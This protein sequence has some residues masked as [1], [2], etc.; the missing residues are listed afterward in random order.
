MASPLSQVSRVQVPDTAIQETL[1]VVREA[2]QRGHE[3]LV[4]WLGVVE[5]NVANIQAVL[6][7]PQNPVRSEE[8]VGYFVN[9]ETL[10]ALNRFLREHKLRLLAQVHSH[11][12]DAF[13]SATDD[14]Y[15]I[16]TVEGGF[17]L[18]IPDFGFGRQTLDEW[19]VY[20]LTS[21]HWREMSVY[22]VRSVFVVT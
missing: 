5:E 22:Q 16:V 2:G 10:F 8:G 11:P 3:V 1:T 21:G 7:P 9:S 12:Q 17:S 4:L 18:V 14:A 6:A 15:A 13:H 20:R 19:A